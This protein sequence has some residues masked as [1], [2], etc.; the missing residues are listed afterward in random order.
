MEEATENTDSK[1]IKE[2]GSRPASSRALA[3]YCWLVLV[4]TLLLLYAGGFTTTIKAGMVFPDW[5]TSNGSF[6][7][8]GWTENQAMLAEHGH[9]LLGMMIGLLSIGLVAALAWWERRAVVRRLGWLAL[10]LVIVQGVLGGARVL[11]DSTEFA[12]IHGCVAQL[13]LCLLATIAVMQTGLWHRLADGPEPTP[14]EK[15]IGRW[16]V[17]LTA[18]LFAQLILAAL[19][20][21]LG[22]GLAIPTF[23]LNPD[24]TLIP[25]HWDAGI[26]LHFAHRALALLIFLKFSFWLTLI[27]KPTIDPVLRRLGVIVFFILCLQILLGISI[28]WTER[29][30]FPTTLH[31]LTGAILLAFTWS[32]TVYFQRPSARPACHPATADH[33]PSSA[34]AYERS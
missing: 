20:R 2:P 33:P 32:L 17:I 23:P 10:A 13:F 18:M 19:V 26:A 27:Y 31:V 4:A 25:R 28:I 6:N 34:I 15:K 29:L 5:P 30:P 11:L 1:M 7:P 14:Q 24:G 16:G 3:F 12:A 22:A 21:H 8:P 9:R